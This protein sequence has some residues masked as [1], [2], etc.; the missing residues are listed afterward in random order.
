MSPRPV[1]TALLVAGLAVPAT[2]SSWICSDPEA[3]TLHH[4]LRR[5]QETIM[6]LKAEWQSRERAYEAKLSETKLLVE[7]LQNTNRN[8]ED[9][10]RDLKDQVPPP[11]PE[12]GWAQAIED[13]RRDGDVN[14]GLTPILDRM[15]HRGLSSHRIRHILHRLSRYDGVLEAAL[16]TPAPEHEL[17]RFGVILDKVER[18]ADSLAQDVVRRLEKLQAE[19]GADFS[20]SNLDSGFGCELGFDDLGGDDLGDDH[21][22][23]GFGLGGDDFGDF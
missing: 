19:Y 22:D 3:E 4:E 9:R 1:L 7:V 15:T 2:A 23:D 12:Q 10:V 16:E 5:S 11:V 6:A 21:P 18:H 20:P 13:L 8:L 17:E 14:V